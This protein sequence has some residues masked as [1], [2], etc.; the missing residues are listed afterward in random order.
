MALDIYKFERILVNLISNAIKFSNRDG[1]IIVKLVKDNDYA[2]ISVEDNGIGIDEKD[3]DII[4][5]KFIQLDNGLNR[6]SEGTG[7]GLSLVK[8][9]A[10][11]PV[12]ILDNMG[13]IQ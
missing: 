4:F 12:M 3:R 6:R 11:L 13:I 2:M 1:V 7:I 9:M 10:E 8:S 5:K